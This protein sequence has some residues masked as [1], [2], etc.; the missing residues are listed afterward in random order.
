MGR[1]YQYDPNLGNPRDAYTRADRAHP[2]ARRPEVAG[3]FV[4]CVEGQTVINTM[5]GRRIV[6][7]RAEPG[8][9]CIILGYWSDGTVHLKWPAILGVYR[10]DGRFP[11]WVV[12]ED[13]TATL[14]GGG[15]LLSA[16]DVPQQ[17]SG[18]SARVFSTAFMLI[19]LVLLAVL[20][21]TRDALGAVMADLLHL[22]P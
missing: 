5:W 13:K 14:A 9:R 3:T 2:D 1:V 4:A 20:P 19:F 16:N 22:L 15:H 10:V 8:T 12:A 18:L 11:A 17:A 7:W 6:V 21:Q